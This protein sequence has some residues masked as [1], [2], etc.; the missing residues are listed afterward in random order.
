M[1]RYLLTVC[2]PDDAVQPPPEELARITR[3]VDTV[4]RELQE[5]GAWIFGGGLHEASTSTVVRVRGGDVLTTDGPF[6]ETHEQ[7]GGLSII[8]VA[9]LDAALQWAERFARATTCAIEVRPF[10]DDAGRPA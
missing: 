5:T 2:Y 7:L 9:D 8:E 10:H 3:D 1:T 6:A 4:H